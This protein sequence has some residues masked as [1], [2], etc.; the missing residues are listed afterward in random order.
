MIRAPT[1]RSPDS[2]TE[3]PSPN[4]ALVQESSLSISAILFKSLPSMLHGPSKPIG[5]GDVDVPDHFQRLEVD[6][7]NVVIAPTGY[8]CAR[9]VWLNLDATRAVDV[10]Q[11][12]DF[13]ACG[14]V[15][16]HEG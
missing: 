14:G 12:L 11:A 15:E 6:H 16:D 13:F 2:A 3:W 9:A 5:T 1:L 10:R 4:C 7:R 8:V